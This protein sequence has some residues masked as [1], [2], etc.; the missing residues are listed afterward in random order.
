MNCLADDTNPWKIEGNA[1]W[2]KIGRTMSEEA[3]R[4]I[5]THYMSMF[6]DYRP[7]Y[8]PDDDP[9]G[10]GDWVFKTAQCEWGLGDCVYEGENLDYDGDGELDNNTITVSFTDGV[11]ND[12]LNMSIPFF[13][14]NVS[15]FAMA[16]KDA[17][18]AILRIIPLFDL[19]LLNGK[20]AV[21]ATDEDIRYGDEVDDITIESEPG[22]YSVD[23][24]VDAMMIDLVEEAYY[25]ET[26]EV[27]DTEIVKMWTVEYNG[28]TGPKQAQVT[29]KDR[30]GTSATSEWLTIR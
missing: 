8:D 15:I 9:V 23:E 21:V 30:W 1:L 20:I 29:V 22:G 2:V 28:L 19:L 26:G 12:T 17:G 11:Y 3:I 4:C 16:F 5:W 14:H 13:N 6:P 7:V 10:M 18:P 25:Q 27:L 24:N